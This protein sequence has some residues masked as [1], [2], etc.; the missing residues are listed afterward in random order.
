MN[1]NDIQ[2]LLSAVQTIAAILSS[3]GVPGLLA[4][5]LS[6][7]ALVIIAVLVM[8]HISITRMEKSQQ[9][10]RDDMR[11]TLEAY[12]TDTQNFVREIGKEHAE[13]V[14]FYNDNVELV[15][16][17]ERIADALQTIIINNTRATERLI[18]IIEARKQ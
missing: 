2:T 11:D 8:T 15:K 14:R 5:A 13:A 9:I 17:Y 3:L 10:F 7:P 12:R 16:D 4:L 18:T 6:G 1:P